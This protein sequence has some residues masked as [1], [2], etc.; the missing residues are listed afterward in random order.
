VTNLMQA[1]RVRQPCV[2]GHSHCPNGSCPLALC[3]IYYRKQML[4]CVSGYAHTMTIFFNDNTPIGG[5]L[6]AF[7]VERKDKDHPTTTDLLMSGNG[8]YGGLGNNSY[9][10]SQGEPTR[11]RGISGFLQCKSPRALGI[12]VKTIY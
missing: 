3:S 9:L 10:N 6:T 8:Q 11:A 5:D 4:E 7:V 12:Y 1:A 2:P